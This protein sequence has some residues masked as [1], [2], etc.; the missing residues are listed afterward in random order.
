MTRNPCT[1]GSNSKWGTL[2]ETSVFIVKPMAPI[3]LT[4]WRYGRGGFTLPISVDCNFLAVNP[5]LEIVFWV[6]Q[7]EQISLT[8]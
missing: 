8:I 6:F 7:I 1:W 3:A 4:F 5:A 2:Q